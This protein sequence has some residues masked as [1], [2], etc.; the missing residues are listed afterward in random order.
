MFGYWCQSHG[1]FP[2]DSARRSAPCPTCGAQSPD[3]PPR[4]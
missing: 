1:F 3:N 4:F 2:R